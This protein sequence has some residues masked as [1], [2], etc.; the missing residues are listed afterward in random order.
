MSG[1]V[2]EVTS[3]TQK[4]TV[5]KAAGIHRDRVFSITIQVVT[6][7]KGTGIKAGAQIQVEAWQPSKRIPPLPG[8]QGHES[9]PKKGD[10]AT[11]YLKGE[12]GKPFKPLLPN[13]ISIKK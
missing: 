4:S 7:L 6:V 9:I 2:V 5:E 13:G 12:K 1:T 11:F 10:T 3:K 8:L